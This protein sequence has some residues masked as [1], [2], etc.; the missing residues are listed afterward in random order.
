MMIIIDIF[1]RVLEYCGWNCFCNEDELFDDE[2][3]VKEKEKRVWNEVM[4]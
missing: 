1:K 3:V 4:K 2:I